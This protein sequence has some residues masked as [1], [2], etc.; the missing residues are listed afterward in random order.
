M[1]RNEKARAHST[2]GKQKRCKWFLVG[3]PGGKTPLVKVRS[4]WE[5]NIKMGL[6]A[7][8]DNSHDARTTKWK[9]LTTEEPV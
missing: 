4:M 3:K 1:R 5:D 2:Y 9:K 7:H 6:Q 8:T